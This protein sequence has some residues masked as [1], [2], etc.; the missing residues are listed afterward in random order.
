MKFELSNLF[1]TPE[2]YR[3][4][5]N[6]KEAATA[7]ETIETNSKELLMDAKLLM[8]NR[9]YA[10][11]VT[12]S[13]LAVEEKGK[14]ELIKALLLCNPGQVYNVWRD[15]NSHKKK[16]FIW[17]YPLLRYYRIHETEK[18]GK[19][20]DPKGTFSECLDNIKQLSLYVDALKDSKGRCEWTLP[21][22]LISEELAKFCYEISEIVVM[23]D[24][25]E[26]NERALDIFVSFAK[27]DGERII[28]TDKSNYMKNCVMKA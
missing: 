12:L 11:A 20:A 18:T 7:I 9:R 22:E 15:V 23:D 14:I 17:M 28:L 13:L 2:P 10:R 21:S 1:D 5:I 4:P 27:H 25:I 19:V 16:N 26:W 24:G 3:R 8:D 6:V